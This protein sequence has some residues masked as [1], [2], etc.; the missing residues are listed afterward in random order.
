MPGK[1]WRR[2]ALLLVMLAIALFMTMSL[3]SFSPADP[4]WFNSGKGE[5]VQNWGG[6][7]GSYLAEFLVQFLGMSAWLEFS[8]CLKI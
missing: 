6:E 3:L 2:E 7:A 5:A 1:P 8:E 4:S